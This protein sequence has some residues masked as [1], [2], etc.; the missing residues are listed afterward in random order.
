LKV[1]WKLAPGARLAFHTPPSD[2]V[3][4]ET[5]SLLVHRTVAPAATVRFP[6][7]KAKPETVTPAV[8]GADVVVVDV[9]VVDEVVVVGEVVTDV[10]LLVVVVVA[11]AAVV[12]GAVVVGDEVVVGDTVVEV[13]GAAPVVVVT[14]AVVLTGAPVEVVAAEGLVVVVA[15]G[16]EAHALTTSTNTAPARMPPR[17]VMASP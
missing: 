17:P 16:V 11:A 12:A 1:N 2:V 10:V 15:A 8:A 14:A 7:W 5:E 3:V 13:V 9:V 4:C 6:E